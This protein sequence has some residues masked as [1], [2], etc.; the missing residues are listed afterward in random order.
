MPRSG[1]PSDFRPELIYP[2]DVRLSPLP[3]P[4]PAIFDNPSRT[5]C[6]NIQWASH[7][8]G[9]LDRLMYE[10]AWTGDEAEF[11]RAKQEIIRLSA[12]LGGTSEEGD[13]IND[14]GCCDEN[15]TAYRI[16]GD[17][18]IQETTDGG[19][20]WHDMPTTPSPQ[21]PRTYFP[22]VTGTDEADIRCKVANS[23]AWWF[24]NLQAQQLQAL[25]NEE[26]ALGISLIFD[27]VLI[28]V[29]LAPFALTA[30]AGA[31][32]AGLVLQKNIADFTA[33]FPSI[34]WSKLAEAAYCNVDSAGVYIDSDPRSIIND[35][36]ASYGASYATEWLNDALQTFNGAG[37][38]NMG[39]AGFNEGIDCAGFC[40]ETCDTIDDWAAQLPG[41]LGTIIARSDHWIDV[42]SEYYSGYGQF[43][44]YINAGHPENFDICC[45]VVG[46]EVDGVTPAEITELTPCGMDGY[47]TSVHNLFHRGIVPTSVNTLGIW[48]GASSKV[49]R[50]FF[51]P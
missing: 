2:Y 35:V 22:P 20:T 7:I 34:F 32:L 38:T 9:L 48:T 41:T 1:K 5:I 45:T 11:E 33:A 31:I 27:G 14:M 40:D 17:G 26:T 39:A 4:T 19:A 12:A 50:F 51:T 49:V 16:N 30:A 3:V 8:Q 42:Q 46:V 21:N 47:S 43:V 44:A 23:V 28:L 10:D 13:C 18:T 36:I 37:L 15:L 29:G 24:H 25:V 6:I